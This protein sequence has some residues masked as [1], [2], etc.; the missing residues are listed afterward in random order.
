MVKSSV[1]I[2]VTDEP[3]Y[4]WR[5]YTA[6]FAVAG[7]TPYNRGTRS[8]TGRSHWYSYLLATWMENKRYVSRTKTL[9]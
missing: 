7:G 5:S 1:Y 4:F 9:V 8:E 2:L 3:L 6:T